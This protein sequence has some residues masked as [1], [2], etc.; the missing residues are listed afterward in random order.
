MLKLLINI[1][2]LFFLKLIKNKKIKTF[3]MRRLIK[4]HITRSIDI[5]KALDLEDFIIVDVGAC[6]GEE[7]DTTQRFNR[8]F[9]DKEIYAFEPFS[10]SYKKL[11]VN[12]NKIKN[13]K[14][15]DI[16]L[17]DY[18]GESK[19]YI[20]DTVSSSSLLKT[21]QSE[22]NK[23]LD[24][25]SAS[26]KCVENA[27]IVKVDRLDNIIKDKIIGILKIDTQGSELSVLRGSEKILNNIAIVVLENNNH[28]VYTNSSKYY[29]TDDY[30]R[31]NG[32]DLY[33]IIPSMYSSGRLYEWDS[34]YINSLMEKK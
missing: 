4:D 27:E 20:T 23:I 8:A 10:G 11:L 3:L 7:K 25:F 32:F 30:L 1:F 9:P 34:I 22:I 6:K 16:A 31:N 21:E 24:E 33:D 15:Y 12:T 19:F 18:K 26:L 17:S 29:E 28:K 5:L 13:I 14:P 2:D